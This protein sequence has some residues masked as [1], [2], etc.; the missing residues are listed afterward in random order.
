MKGW[1][2]VVGVFVAISMLVGVGL[3]IGWD[4]GRGERDSLRRQ[5]EWSVA[6]Q[7]RYRDLLSTEVTLGKSRAARAESAEM[8]LVSC[9]KVK[10]YCCWLE[11][12]RLGQP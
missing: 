12:K 6:D 8:L 10:N 4:I 1:V 11:Q 5:L 3:L 2:F 9:R 7:E